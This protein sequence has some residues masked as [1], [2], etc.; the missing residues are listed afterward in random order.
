MALIQPFRAL[1][2]NPQGV[3][4]LGAVL[5]PPYDVITPEEQ[6]R[7]YQ[8]SD[9]NIVRLIL[10]SQYPTD[11]EGDDRYSRAKA[12]F[13][14]W[15][16]QGV[17]SRDPTLAFYVIEH[18]FS[19]FETDSSPK[20]SAPDKG[21]QQSRLGFIA[22][23]G[24]EDSMERTAYRHEATLTAPK[25]DRK[26]LLEAIPAN[27]SPIFCLYPDP[28][29][30]VQSLL[31]EH[32][33]KTAPTVEAPFKQDTVRLWVATDASWIQEIQRQLA[34]ATVLIADGHHRFEVAY[35]RK[36]QYPALMSYFVSLKDPALCMHAIHRVV[37]RDSETGEEPLSQLCTLEATQ[38]LSSVMMRLGHSQK[39]PVQPSEPGAFHGQ[40]GF[41]N[42]KVWYYV[43][44]KPRSVESWLGTCSI[45]QPI[46]SLDVCLL[47]QFLLPNLVNH[48]SKVGQSGKVLD[49]QS[50][51]KWKIIDYT[52]SAKQ[53]VCA[54]DRGQG[55]EAWFL[56]AMSLEQIYSLAARGFIL[57]P[58]STYFY[59]KVLSGLTI[60]PLAGC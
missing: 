4:Q 28:D 52:A 2:Y 25:A 10:G 55:T 15:C 29:G 22:L 54:V 46:A 5:A 19:D 38:N 26:K 31:R 58:K 8:C 35:A 37:R 33:R 30:I 21:F 40:F 50:Q 53:A 14:A 18:Q 44:L 27:L 11:R 6:Q 49:E 16:T 1:R 45:P 41:Y 32:V 17:F 34:A 20:Q 42:G 57:P 12:A 51:A 9:Y 43:S 24:F 36:H 47:Q 48:A 7:L 39:Q 23:L 13:N 56:R 3:P 60:N 59:P